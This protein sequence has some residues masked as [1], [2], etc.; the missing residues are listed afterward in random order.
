[1]SVINA[2]IRVNHLLEG[3]PLHSRLKDQPT[4]ISSICKFG[5]YDWL[6]YRV[7]G[8]KSPL[9]HQRL[10]KA[11]GPSKNPVSA[12]S[13][14]LVT[15][16]GYI[17]PIQMLRKLMPSE[18]SIPVML[19]RMKEF[20]D[21]TKNKYEEIM[22]IPKD[23]Y[24]SSNIHPKHNDEPSNVDSGEME[25]SMFRMKDMRMYMGT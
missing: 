20:D 11:L 15:G 14:W 21:P 6:I 19:K 5:W 12:I 13:Q 7:E 1:M 3:Q 9:Q 8:H 4:E 23:Q 22:S 16:N 2:T 17:M 25:I 10:G 24:F 18:M